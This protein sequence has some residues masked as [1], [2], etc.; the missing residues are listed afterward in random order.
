VVTS[1]LISHPSKN[2]PIVKTSFST[3]FIPNGN[4]MS[5]E[6]FE[7]DLSKISLDLLSLTFWGWV[8]L[9]PGPCPSPWSILMVSVGV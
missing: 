3:N 4:E 9:V 2:S 5:N 6:M 7:R 8:R 1:P